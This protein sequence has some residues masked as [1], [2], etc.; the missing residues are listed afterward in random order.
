MKL[1]TVQYFSILLLGSVASQEIPCILWNPKVHYRV[2][3]NP[4]IFPVLSHTN[5]LYVFPSYILNVHYSIILPLTSVSS[6]LPLSLG[7]FHQTLH[8][9]FPAVHA[10]CPGHQKQG[11]SYVLSVESESASSYVANNTTC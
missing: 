7:F 3:N 9:F 4:S 11:K 10:T 1:I 5:P 6:K 2:R 8:A